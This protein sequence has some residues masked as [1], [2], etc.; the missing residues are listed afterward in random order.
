M[1]ELSKISLKHN[2]AIYHKYYK[3]TQGWDWKS[4]PFANLEIIPDRSE[5]P[6]AS[7]KLSFEVE[8]DFLQQQ[9]TLK[10]N[11]PVKLN[12][13]NAREKNRKI[14]ITITDEIASKTPSP[15]GNVYGSFVLS[16]EAPTE[17]QIIPISI[18]LEGLETKKSS[19]YVYFEEEKI[20]SSTG[21]SD[22]VAIC[23]EGFEAFLEYF[24]IS[25]CLWQNG[26]IILPDSYENIYMTHSGPSPEFEWSGAENGTNNEI[27][28]YRIIW[29]ENSYTGKVIYGSQDVVNNAFII[30]KIGGEYERGQF[31][32]V[33]VQI[34]GNTTDERYRYSKPITAILG[35]INNLPEISVSYSEGMVQSNGQVRFTINI[36]D[37]DNQEQTYFVKID[38]QQERQYDIYPLEF[39]IQELNL[40]PGLHSITFQAYDGLERGNIVTRNFKVNQ[41]P[42]IEAPQVIHNILQ[43]FSSTPLAI[44]SIITYELNKNISTA[45]AKIKLKLKNVETGRQM[46]FFDSSI[47]NSDFTSKRIS[48]NLSSLSTLSSFITNG[49]KYQYSFSIYDGVEWSDYTDYLEVARYPSLPPLPQYIING[50]GNSD[51]IEENFF[52]SGIQVE[53]FLPYPDEDSGYLYLSEFQLK[54]TQNS[55]LNEEEV[56]LSLPPQHFTLSYGE[57][58]TVIMPMVEHNISTTNLYNI[59]LN[60]E[61]VDTI[62][63][64]NQ[65]VITGTD[66]INFSKSYPPVFAEGAFASVSLEIIK[67]LSNITNFVISHTAA[68]CE[69]S[70]INYIYKAK[71]ESEEEIVEEFSQNQ[72]GQTIEISIVA[73]EINQ[74]LKEMVIDYNKKYTVTWQII[75][76]DGFGRRVSLV[77]SNL[78][79]FQEEPYWSAGAQLSLKHDYDISNLNN[80]AIA[81]VPPVTLGENYLDIRMFNPQE[82]IIFNFPKA[83]DLNND[84]VQYQFFLSRYDLTDDINLEELQTR[85]NNPNN[86]SFNSVPFLILTPDQLVENNNIYQYRYTASQY[87]KNEV[88][89][90]KICAKDS[91][92]LISKPIF[93][94]TYIIGCRTSKPYFEIKNYKLHT[95]NL[96]EAGEPT[97]ITITNNLKINDLGGSTLEFWRESYYNEYKN[98]ERQLPEY[99]A[100]I[101]LK[102][103][104]SLNSDFSHSL[105][106]WRLENQ[107]FLDFDE[108]S[109]EANFQ[110]LDDAETRATTSPSIQDFMGKKIY[111]RFTLVISTGLQTGS[112]IEGIDD[113]NNLHTVLSVSRAFT[114]S[115]TAPT[116]AYRPHRV[117]INVDEE[118]FS[119]HDVL[120]L[121]SYKNNKL[122]NYLVRML[123]DSSLHGTAEAIEI[124]FNLAQ[125]TMDGAFI[126]GGAW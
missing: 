19:L 103:E 111:V 89:Y 28:G 96:N 97:L 38:S 85:L 100:K 15:V 20:S 45:S 126:S 101:G 30:P 1:S 23:A 10:L 75:A 55:F 102:T 119:E 26:T 17:L 25:Q 88:F 9:A 108:I 18:Q 31:I 95:G 112:G 70:L 109:F 67:P 2:Q 107:N 41:K 82:G 65:T 62:G 117:G 3:W 123:G 124:I 57:S 121:S 80:Q 61:S 94:N 78:A 46:E 56:L 90:F 37:P 12:N 11:L 52:S 86:I 50:D 58:K 13:S 98:F 83:Q 54:G 4:G 92:G 36:T 110:S 74:L 5:H 104:I 125:G 48:I 44:S 71:I 120:T 79:D 6:V 118:N 106:H 81:E 14:K 7:L 105:S 53:L 34:I 49:D 22:F 32:I 113:F 40:G 59:N 64:R 87:I 21:S 115:G 116:V 42:Q 76:E 93:S 43:G 27:A 33:D 63:Q 73:N 35:R 39:N 16:F 114:S 66:G 8:K 84:I 91:T 122:D 68:I 72:L 60:L 99:D 24:P 47:F 69:G 29:Y 51:L 77:T